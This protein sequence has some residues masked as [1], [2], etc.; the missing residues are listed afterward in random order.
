M[1]CERCK[2]REASVVL[3]EVIN[4]VKTEHNLCSQCATDTDLLKFYRESLGS[5]L[6]PRTLKRRR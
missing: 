5:F 4:G 3:T 6:K 1:L 2:M